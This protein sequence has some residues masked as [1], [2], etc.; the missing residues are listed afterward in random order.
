[1]DSWADPADHY[2][3]YCYHDDTK[4]HFERPPT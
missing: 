1:M 3:N 2:V 4:T